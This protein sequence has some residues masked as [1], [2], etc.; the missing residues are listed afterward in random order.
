MWVRGREEVRGQAYHVRVAIESVDMLGEFLDWV[1]GEDT[2]A[3]AND[4]T[5]RQVLINGQKSRKR[6]TRPLPFPCL[7]TY[8]LLQSVPG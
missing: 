4:A 3:A 6:R 7:S 1:F 5:E 8:Q 2:E